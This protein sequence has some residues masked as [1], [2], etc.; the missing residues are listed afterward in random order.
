MAIVNNDASLEPITRDLGQ[1]TKSLPIRGGCAGCG[2]HLDAP[3]SI[4]RFDDQVHFNLVLIAIMSEPGFEITPPCH[5]NY[6]LHDE[7]LEQ[8]PEAGAFIIPLFCR[9]IRKSRGQSTVVEVD[10]GGIRWRQPLN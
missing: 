3:D 1:S 10:L 9:Q 6:L 8:V 4:L 7:R 2:F 5:S